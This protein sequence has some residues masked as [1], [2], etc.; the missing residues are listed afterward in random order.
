MT[1]N[2]SPAIRPHGQ[3]PQTTEIVVATGNAHKVLELAAIFKP[4]FH[5]DFRLSTVTAVAPAYH[6]PDEDGDTFHENA[7]IKAQTAA[8]RTGR[9]ALAD[10]SGLMVRGLNMAPGIH[11]ARY[12]ASP[13]PASGRQPTDAENRAKLLTDCAGLNDIDLAAWFFCCLCLAI[14]PAEDQR[15][16]IAGSSSLGLSRVYFFTGIVAGRIQPREQGEHGFGYDPVFLLPHLSR[17][18]AELSAAEKNTLSHRAIAASRL[19][20]FLMRGGAVFD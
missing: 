6:P 2:T 5:A 16:D 10:D 12:A 18:M 13:N 19:E 7:L 20:H 8:L 11:S 1:E 17:T 3:A 14:P 15:R 4:A 9:P